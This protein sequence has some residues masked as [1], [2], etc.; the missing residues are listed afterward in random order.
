MI[1]NKIIL[2]E[3]GNWNCWGQ[4][5]RC[6]GMPHKGSNESQIPQKSFENC[7]QCCQG[8][9][10][11]SKGSKE[12]FERKR[13]SSLDEGD[14]FQMKK[15]NQWTFF[16]LKGF[17]SFLILMM[18]RSFL[19]SLRV[20]RISRVS[21]SGSTPSSFS[22]AKSPKTT[23]TMTTELLGNLRYK[24]DNNWLVLIDIISNSG[25]NQNIQVTFTK[26]FEWSHSDGWVKFL[27]SL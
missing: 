16:L 12:K 19:M 8:H 26:R 4:A 13:K 5:G 21:L 17:A 14:Y 1:R 18:F 2:G 6:W 7:H 3:Q 20:R 11:K 25:L 9:Q 22:E 10:K 27:C 24:E 15:F 23:S